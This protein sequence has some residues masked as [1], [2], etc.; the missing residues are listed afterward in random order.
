MSHKTQH[1]RI[2]IAHA[3][4][5]QKA[6]DTLL[7]HLNVLKEQG[8]QIRSKT[9][10]IAGTEYKKATE[11]ELNQADIVLSLISSQFIASEEFQKLKRLLTE[12]K[13]KH[14][15]P[16]LLRP[17]LWKDDSFLQQFSPLPKNEIAVSETAVQYQDG[18]YKEIAEELKRI[19]FGQEKP[20]KPDP[21]VSRKGYVLAG[22][23]ATMFLLG[24]LFFWQS[25]NKSNKELSFS[26]IPFPSSDSVFTVLILRFED[27]VNE[28]D[29][30]YCIGRSI[31]ELLINIENKGLP[32]ASIYADS[33]LSP[34]R[35]KEAKRIQKQYN[36]DLLLYG[37]ANQ[38]QEDCSEANI[39]FRHS[40]ADTIMANVEV[41]KHITKTKHDSKYEA[42]SPMDIERG[43]LSVDKQTMEAWISHLIA[44]KDDDTQATIAAIDKMFEQV[45]KL[46]DRKEAYS[47]LKQ[48]ETF[49]SIKQYEKAILSLKKAIESDSNY[50]A[51]YNSLG[52]VYRELKGY[53]K[54]ID[55]LNK[56]ILLNPTYPE[57]FHNR[58][59]T[60]FLMK[61]FN[62]A[63]SDFDKVV[64]LSPKDINAYISRGST[65]SKL[66]NYEK[67]INDL[68][69]V[70]LLDSTYEQAYAN[71]GRICL[72]SKKYENAIS[73]FSKALQLNPR[74]PLSYNNRGAAYSG[75]K[76]YK[77]AISDFDKALQLN[78]N[79]AQIY[80]NRAEVY[81]H[82]KN[83]EKSINDLNKA[84]QL[85]LKGNVVYQLRGMNYISLKEYEKAL[86]DFNTAIQ[87]NPKLANTY[88]F[89]AIA[90]AGMGEHRKAIHD[91]DRALRLAPED[92]MA[93][94]CRASSYTAIDMYKEAEHDYMKLIKMYPEVQNTAAYKKFLKCKNKQ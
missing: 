34:K 29:N 44:L 49:Y 5:D 23:L 19:V 8:V 63:L 91:C 12:Q 3:P 77:K 87:L 94:L 70:I 66:K 35:K 78:P 38:I 50:I 27:N 73:S 30:T 56:A 31:E 22:I 61:E 80:H 48:G 86:N 20:P 10:F 81:Y 58:G 51:S 42:T 4:E 9:D 55:I 89:R 7:S 68:N 16:V 26:Q 82:L 33:I 2:F 46:S 13:N 57:T 75:L 76:E 11:D 79:Q 71:I 93:Y 53:K 67:A 85:A 32:I 88:S 43:Q 39:C 64:Q 36:A 41:P 17:C 59:N 6:Y 84:I 65:Y 69:K 45:K 14:I 21:D 25:S 47:Y 18:I 72:D 15:V 60:Y 24:G 90:Y 74:N 62:K 83:Y 54:S 28:D 37:L 40:V 92:F 1:T 52:Y